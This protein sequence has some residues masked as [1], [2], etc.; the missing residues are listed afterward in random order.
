MLPSRPTTI[1]YA[2]PWTH[3]GFKYDPAAQEGLG[4]DAGDVEAIVSLVLLALLVFPAVCWYVGNAGAMMLLR[5]T[6]SRKRRSSALHV[7]GQLW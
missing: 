3:F 6:T 2:E 7:S 5:V 4:W 1:E